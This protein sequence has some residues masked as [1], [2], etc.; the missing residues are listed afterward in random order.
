MSESVYKSPAVL[1]LCIN[2]SSWGF[3]LIPQHRQQTSA[4][5]WHMKIEILL[6][7]QLRLLNRL[8]FKT[9]YR[10]LETGLKPVNR[11]DVIA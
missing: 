8:Y 5:Y 1:Q 9:G 11:Y 6:V 4:T 7:S 3:Q 2:C 10:F